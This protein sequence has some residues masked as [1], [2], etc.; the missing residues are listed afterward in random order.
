MAARRGRVVLA[1][2]QL[3]DIFR[4][5][6]WRAVEFLGALSYSLYL[7]HHVAIM[8]V[9]ALLPDAGKLAQ[10]LLAFGLSIAIALAIYLLIERPLAKVRRGFSAESSLAGRPPTGA[11]V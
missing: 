4:P 1:L 9:E 6:N 7:V 3:L 11:T 5:L 8:R 2:R 10:V